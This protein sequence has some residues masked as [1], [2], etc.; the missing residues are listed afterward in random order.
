MVALL[1]LTVVAAAVDHQEDVAQVER[2]SDGMLVEQDLFVV[3]AELFADPVEVD[4]AVV[5]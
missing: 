1:P 3:F 5:D 4:D 2:V